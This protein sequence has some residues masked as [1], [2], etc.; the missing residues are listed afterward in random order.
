MKSWGK[1]L[2]HTRFEVG[3]SSKVRDSG[4]ISVVGCGL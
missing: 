4:M 3:D 2:H 1:L